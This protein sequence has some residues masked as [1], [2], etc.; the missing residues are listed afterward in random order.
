MFKK[1]FLILTIVSGTCLTQIQDTMAMRNGFDFIDPEKVEFTKMATL[2]TWIAS[3]YHSNINFMRE[4]QRNISLVIPQNPFS[5]YFSACTSIIRD[6]NK[7]KFYGK[8]L[9]TISSIELPFLQFVHSLKNPIT[10]EIGAGIGLVSWKVPLAFE[11]NGTHY[12][13]EL[14]PKLIDS[15]KTQVVTNYLGKTDL[16]TSIRILPGSCF[17]ILKTHSELKNSCNA[18][19]VANVEHFFNPAEHQKFLTLLEELLA[20]GGQAFLTSHSFMFDTNANHPLRRLYFS[21]KKVNDTYPGFAKY[22]IEFLK[23]QGTGET[24]ANNLKYTNVTRPSDNT[25][26]DTIPLSKPIFHSIMNTQSG[27]KHI[28]KHHEIT[29]CNAFSPRVYRNA[30]AL[31]PS[32]EVVDTF[33]V[34]RVGEREK[35]WNDNISHA[36]VIVRKK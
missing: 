21:R 14:N 7:E 17:D 36:A 16:A 4:T 35:S 3:K 33:F 2:K 5:V 12:V 34:N 32:L 22:N 11:N 31:H 18:I 27:I 10:L 30:I 25:E 23:I 6:G 9:P 26:V 19:F 24:I 15:F 28:F 29:I 8:M 20:P 13:N 1:L